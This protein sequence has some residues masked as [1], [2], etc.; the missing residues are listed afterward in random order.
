MST[1]LPEPARQTPVIWEGDLVVIGGSCTGLFAAIRAAR[2]GLRV[3][4]VERAGCFGGVATISL[5][6]VW[7]SCYDEVFEKQIFAGLTLEVIER[8]RRRDSVVERLRSDAWQWCFNPNEL[9]IELDELV[10]EHGIKPYL[11][12]MFVA[13]YREGGAAEPTAP[14]RGVVVENKS[15]RGILLARQFVD[16]SGDGDLAEKLGLET[17]R[18]ASGQP[19]TTCAIFS[20]WEQ[21]KGIDW[22][23]L[24]RDHGPEFG[25]KPGFAWGAFLPGGAG[26]M[27]AGT[28][29][30]EP[31]EEGDSLTAAE[32]EGRRQVRAIHDLL[33][34][35]L[36]EIDLRLL[37]LPARL[38]IRETRHA[39][40]RHELTETEVL[41]GVRFPDAI[42]AGSYRVDVH[43]HDKPGITFR[44]LDGREN[45]VR[46]GHPSVEGRWRPERA[47][48]PTFYQIPFRTLIPAG[49]PPNLLMAG[50]MSDA[51]AGAHAAIRVMVNM[52]QTGE[53]AG[54]AAALAV[55]AGIEASEVEAGR[56]R[57]A[58]GK[59]G[60]LVL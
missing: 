6:N 53:A 42:A 25:L 24:V 54:T 47:V 60:S 17:Y 14:L 27:L 51:D 37:A 33:R 45:Y 2:M 35:Y 32:M 57:E 55:Q 20:G 40:C 16:A 15:G 9:Q 5:V 49:G 1:L 44:Y 18:R 22:Q 11:H 59:G 43:H 38:G 48:N 50:R 30:H 29:I 52:N 13:P 34:K 3:A 28:R 39:R 26:Y 31:A 10:R 58:L 41:E 56:L 4:V 7:H 21:L 12:T 19:S 23:G 36:P 8:L 46:P